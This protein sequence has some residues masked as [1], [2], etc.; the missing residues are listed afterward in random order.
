[1]QMS[2]MVEA[3]K[4]GSTYLVILTVDGQEYEYEMSDNAHQPNGVCISLG[5]KNRSQ[6]Q[7]G[8][9]V[10]SIPIGIARQCCKLV[11]ICLR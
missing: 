2:I 5:S 7:L 6:M 11:A 8:W 10:E 3:W 9:L 1:M 4:W